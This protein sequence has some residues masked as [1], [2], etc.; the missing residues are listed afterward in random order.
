MKVKL[1]INVPL[2]ISDSVTDVTFTNTV[3]VSLDC[4]QCRRCNRSVVLDKLEFLSYCTPSQ[5]KFKG[6][7]LSIR[8]TKNEKLALI[9]GHY[10]IEYEFGSFR[11]YKYPTRIPAPGSR[12][13]RATF[14]IRCR[15]GV[16]S[17]HVTQN[18]I[19]R[20]FNN[21]CECG[22]ILVKEVEEIPQIQVIS[23]P[24]P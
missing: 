15:C 10:L 16:N 6:K 13:A 3:M 9:T 1:Q 17:T 23:A 24:T 2:H 21:L 19:V 7:V 12:W 14:A 11:D 8:S 4:N 18:N 5:H 22:V 20:P